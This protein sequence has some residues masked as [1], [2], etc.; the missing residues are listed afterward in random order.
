[1]SKNTVKLKITKHS[2]AMLQILHLLIVQ[3][4]QT[5]GKFLQISKFRLNLKLEYHKI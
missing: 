2:C 3:Q 4:F 1:M 5:E